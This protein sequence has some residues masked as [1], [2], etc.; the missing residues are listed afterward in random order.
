MNECYILSMVNTL[1]LQF[2]KGQVEP[3]GSNILYIQVWYVSY[4]C[5]Y[6]LQI[7]N[8]VD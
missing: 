2:Q 8:A 6:I 5:F 1:C 4:L 3:N 7:M